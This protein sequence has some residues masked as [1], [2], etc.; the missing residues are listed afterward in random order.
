M[1]T[2][3][4]KSTTGKTVA[5]ENYVV[6]VNPGLQSTSQIEALDAFIGSSISRYD[7]GILTSADNISTASLALDTSG[8]IT[9]LV[10]P[11]GVKY[12]GIV[13]SVDALFIFRC[14]M[15]FMNG[16]RKSQSQSPY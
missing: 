7:D 16:L 1:T 8:N 12:G 3:I 5:V 4:Y 11:G 13:A 14:A 15:L 9:G 6:T 10:G 2:Y